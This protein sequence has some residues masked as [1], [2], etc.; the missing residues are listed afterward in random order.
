MPEHALT[1]H[2]IL[3]S[4]TRM[5]CPNLKTLNVIGQG[6]PKEQIRYHMPKQVRSPGPRRMTILDIYQYNCLCTDHE[7]LTTSKIEILMVAE[8]SSRK[9]QNTSLLGS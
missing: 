2:K 5:S 9:Y 1:R 8:I 7:N 6:G 4:P 3:Y